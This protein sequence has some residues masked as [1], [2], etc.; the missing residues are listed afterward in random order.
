M[1]LAEQNQYW[2]DLIST[3]NECKLP[4]WL[5][6]IPGKA[7]ED[8]ISSLLYP[9]SGRHSALPTTD[10]VRKDSIFTVETS[11]GFPELYFDLF[12]QNGILLRVYVVT[13]SLNRPPSDPIY[14]PQLTEA[15]QIYSLDQVLT[16]Y[17]KPSRVLIGV[18]SGPAEAGAPW[19]YHLFVIYD[20]LSFMIYYEGGDLHRLG[21]TISVC[22]S[23]LKLSYLTMFLQ[24]PESES[25]L[26]VFVQDI[27]GVSLEDMASQGMFMDLKSAANISLEDFYLKFKQSNP[28]TCIE[29]NANLWR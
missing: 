16:I 4:C 15:M 13:D 17:G 11:D 21:D 25:T 10:Y 24:S 5:G 28:E 12:D 20:N 3:N 6:L 7:T 8:D 22:P 27:Y 9:I 14:A 1:S 19:L 26:D 2:I 23:Y 29:T 18:K